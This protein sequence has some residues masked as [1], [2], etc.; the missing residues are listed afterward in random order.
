[1]RG[2]PPQMR[3]FKTYNP[4]ITFVT[5]YGLMK[6]D[7]KQT[8][9]L[10]KNAMSPFRNVLDIV[11]FKRGTFLANTAQIVMELDEEKTIDG[12]IHASDYIIHAV[13]K[14]VSKGCTYCKKEGHIRADC[15]T[16][17]QS[18]HD[19]SR[20]A[21]KQSQQSA[22]DSPQNE[23]RAKRKKVAVQLTQP[24]TTD[25]LP[26]GQMPN[27]PT[28]RNKAS[29]TLNAATRPSNT[30]LA[31]PTKPRMQT[32]A[33][34]S[35]AK[36]TAPATETPG[37]F[38][39]TVH[40]PSATTVTPP[41]VPSGPPLPEGPFS[42]SLPNTDEPPTTEVVTPP[43]S[44]ETPAPGPLT[45]E[46][47]PLSDNTPTKGTNTLAEPT[48]VKPVVQTTKVDKAGDTRVTYESMQVDDDESDDSSAPSHTDSLL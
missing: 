32:R 3:A 39:A 24:P 19:R 29:S 33:Q 21:E 37:K 26:M 34:T 47:P 45:V 12:F 7:A 38:T 15:P 2:Q 13:G 30:Q 9:I 35:A 42:F 16:R 20:Q 28:T 23:A 4:K 5:L 22:P 18:K 40:P 10:A 25:I 44:T 1:M 17:P 48:S 14:H 43:P 11:L 41:L 27:N 6:A 46:S 31:T 8:A 36:Q